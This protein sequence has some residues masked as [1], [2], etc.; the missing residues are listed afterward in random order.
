MSPANKCENVSYE[1]M[2]SGRQPCVIGVVNV[3]MAILGEILY[4]GE[5]YSTVQYFLRRNTEGQCCFL[6]LA[7]KIVTFFRPFAWFV[8]IKNIMEVV[9]N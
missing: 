1:R 9:K 5:Q 3:H 2:D 4:I 6:H 7:P 8:G